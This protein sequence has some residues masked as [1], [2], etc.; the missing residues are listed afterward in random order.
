[1]KIA[2]VHNR[3]AWPGRGSGEEVM[4]EAMRELLASKGHLVFP[5][6]RSSLELQ[7]MRFGHVH[8]FFSGI[9]N[10][11]AKQAFAHFLAAVKPDMVLI[12]NLY[13]LLSPSILHA[14]RAANLPVLMRCPNY[15]LLCPNGKFMTAGR[16][17]EKCSGGHDYWCFFKNCE[18]NI[19]KS[20]GYA[21]RSLVARQLAIFKNNVDIFMVLTPFAKEKFI[22]NGFDPERI[23]VLSGLADPTSF[24]PTTISKAGSYVGFAGRLSHE[25]GVDTVIQAA[26][27]LPAIDFKIAGAYAH[28]PQLVREAPNNV[29]FLGQLGREELRRFYRNAR[30]IVAPSQWYEGLPVVILEAMLAARPV[31]GSR[32]GGLPDIIDDERTGLLVDPHDHGAWREK[33]AY[34]WEAFELC[35]RFGN[36]G[37]QKAE[38]AYSPDAFY[39]R[40][41]IAYQAGLKRRMAQAEAAAS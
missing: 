20:A 3:Y 15:R 6:V 18:Q 28:M 14:C 4:F 39:H 27:A 21:L 1:M 5:Y 23:H 13:P 35:Q 11:K 10:V 41:M 7:Q 37:R 33:I 34:L 29:C 19:F 40:L 9:Y 8:A 26:K 16:V 12:Q 22:Q 30:F 17:C 2:L 31:I 25:K 36:A 24:T 32:I 38:A